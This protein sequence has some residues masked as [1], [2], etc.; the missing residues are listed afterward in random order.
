MYLM[1]PEGEFVEHYTRETPEKRME[2]KVRK[3]I[4]AYEAA[5]KS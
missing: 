2:I 5:K 1:N 4:Q 3:Q